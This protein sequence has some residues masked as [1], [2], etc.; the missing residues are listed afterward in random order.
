MT[1]VDVCPERDPKPISRAEAR[2]RGAYRYPEPVRTI[3]PFAP[4]GG[5]WSDGSRGSFAATPGGE[6]SFRVRLDHGPGSYFL[7][8]F[9]GEGHVYGRPLSPIAVPMV[10][11]E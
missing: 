1:A 5:T 6:V 11:V 8:V 4:P 9:G 10:R 7:Q 2:R 3:R